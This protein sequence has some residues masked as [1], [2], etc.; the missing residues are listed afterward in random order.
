MP[1]DAASRTS[2]R[3]LQGKGVGA[4]IVSGVEQLGDAS[5]RPPSAAVADAGNRAIG[6]GSE[7]QP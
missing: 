3:R 1:N 4:S 5:G 6:C 2:R 7:G